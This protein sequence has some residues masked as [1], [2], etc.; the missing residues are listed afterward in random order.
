MKIIETTS[1]LQ[2]IEKG[3]VLSIGNFDGV[4]LG[5]QEILATARQTAVE[6]RTPLLVITFEPHPLA[7]LDPQKSPGI[8]TPLALK[9]KLL[10]G[11]GVDYLLVI[12]STRRLLALSPRDFAQQFI[13]KDIQP[14]IM[15]EGESFNFGSGRAGSIETL[16]EL[17]AEKGF[18]VHVVKAKEIKLASGQ[19]V[20][21]SSTAIRDM[22]KS[23]R[24]ADAAVSL[25][26]P[27]RLI[28][29][30][31]PGQGKGKQ[32][33]FPTANIQPTGQLIPAEGV[34]AGFVEVGAVAEQVCMTE[35]RVPAA[36]SIGRAQTL[37]TD[38]PLQ[39]EAHILTGDVGDLHGKF[40]GV[41]FVRRIRDQQKF[42]TEAQ[43]S[44][45]IERDCQ[46]IRQI[47]KTNSAGR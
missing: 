6:R 30:V 10:A 16:Q 37:G 35:N 27:Y 3:C 39:V 9:Q 36:L 1:Q 2:Q 20:R 23:G 21:I 7:V 14:S 47:L 24:V 43:L 12:P 44:T 46:S 40:V 11:S 33:G 17:G 19:W 29:Q 4:H 45:Q 26:R 28:G 32:L 15:V 5:H 22:L 25:G 34:Y 31:V 42:R 13:V 41:D 38:N 8:L 18:E